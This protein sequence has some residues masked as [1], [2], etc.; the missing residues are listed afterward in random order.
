MSKLYQVWIA[1]LEHCVSPAP[2][3]RG[4]RAEAEAMRRELERTE[5]RLKGKLS[6]S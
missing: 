3:F 5:P 1:G 6:V 2:D 4:T